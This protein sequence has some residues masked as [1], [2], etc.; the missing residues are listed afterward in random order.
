MNIMGIDCEKFQQKEVII[1]RLTR[2]INEASNVSEKAV[3]AN[4]L[5]QEVG[6]LLSCEDYDSKNNNCINC[7][8]VANLR[9]KTASL[10]L[11]AKEI[12]D[13]RD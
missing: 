9:K 6:V 3:L 1:K 13:K 11:K 4:Q 10:I 8:I 7:H 12:K 2:K 5:L